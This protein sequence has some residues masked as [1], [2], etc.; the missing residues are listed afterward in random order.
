MTQKVSKRKIGLRSHNRLVAKV[1]RITR[2]GAEERLVAVGFLQSGPYDLVITD[3][4]MPNINGLSLVKKIRGELDLK[5]PVIIIT[6]MG[7]EA[8]RDEGLSLG[9]NSYLTKPFNAPN[10][11]KTAT[12]LM[13]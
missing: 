10:V 2:V 12:E 8:D 13:Q 4:N 7:K 6:I 9:A 11:V 1:I 3:I 5:V